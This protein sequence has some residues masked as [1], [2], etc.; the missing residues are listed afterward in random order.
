M[1]RTKQSQSAEPP[2][3]ETFT[4]QIPEIFQQA[5]TSTANHNKNYVALSKLFSGC[6]GIYEEVQGRGGGIRLTG[7]K[8][9][10]LTF[11]KMVNNVLPVKKGVSNADRV[12]KFIG[13]FVK[14]ITDRGKSIC[15]S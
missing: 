8:S 14:F 15:D 2:T 7:E 3:P 11:A 9:F 1:R 6:A 10:Q 12:V 5:Q 4:S 13:G